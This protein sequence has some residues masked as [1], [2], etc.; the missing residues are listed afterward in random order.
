[1]KALA[2][3]I[4]EQRTELEQFFLESLA[5]VKSIIL[6][7]KKKSI[8]ENVQDFNHRRAT[9]IRT[10]GNNRKSA[11]IPV[12]TGTFPNIKPNR[13][14]H[15]DNEMR[16]SNLPSNENDK[17]YLHELSWEDKELVLR[18]LFAKMNG[19]N[20]NMNHAVQNTKRGGTKSSK[21]SPVFISE[22][23]GVLPTEE[24]GEYQEYF[25]LPGY[26]EDLGVPS[27]PNYSIP[28]EQLDPDDTQMTA[29]Y[30]FRGDEGS[31]VHLA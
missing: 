15:L 14:H 9:S 6:E 3:T 7:R 27:D 30:E 10:W 21:N 19:S 29:G 24:G 12:K 8:A 22:G 4:L 13:L 20:A 11:G 2:A 25:S 16:E 17:V 26:T 28:M 18:L 23:K 5:E 1:M 31:K